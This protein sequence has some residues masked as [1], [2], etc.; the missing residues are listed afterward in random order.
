MLHDLPF[1]YVRLYVAAMRY[2]LTLCLAGFAWAGEDAVLASGARLHVDRHESSGNKVVLHLGA[3][4]IEM[5]PSDIRGFEPDTPPPAVPA[6]SPAATAP[7]PAPEQL[8]DRAA[9]KYGLPS[10]LLRS[11]MKAESGFH[12]QAVSAKGAVGL[13]QLMPSTARDLGADPRDPAQNVDAGA[14]YLRALLEKYSGEL[15][16]ALAAYNAGP[17]AVERF[18]GVP[19]FSETLEYIRRIE[20]EW[21]ASAKVESNP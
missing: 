18:G 2:L 17:G 4:V 16:P 21:K 19:P 15:R 14:R 10:S 20:R 1:F 3:G 5:D 7:S 9:Q 11:V 6:A 8:A 12:P 13:M